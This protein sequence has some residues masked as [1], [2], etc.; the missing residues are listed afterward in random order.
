MTD[1]HPMPFAA[2][3]FERRADE[4]W[5][6]EVPLSRVAEA[7]DT[8]CYVYSR[9]KIETNFR[10]YENAL[11]GTPHL[12]C[13]AMKANSTLGILQILARL[14]AGVDTV[15]GGEIARALRAGFP[16]EKI[17]FS[18]V[19]KTHREIEFALSQKI[20]CFNIESEPELELLNEIASAKGV[21]AP[22]SIR[23]NPDVDAK[24]HPY[25]ST[26]LKNNK[27]GIPIERVEALYLRAA[28]MPGLEVR[29]IDAHIGSQITEVAPFLDSAAK[30]IDVMIRLRA[31]GIRLHHLDIGGG[32]GIRYRPEDTPPEP[33]ELLTPIRTMLNE[34]GL[35]ATEI[36]VEPGRSI[37][38]DA[39]VMLTPVQYVKHGEA[40]D[41][42]IVEGSMSNLIRPA[43]YSAWMAI[44]PV[45]LRRNRKPLIM[46]VV[47][48]VCESSDFLG[49]ARELAVDP[50]DWLA[51]TDAGAYGASMAS[52]YN[53]RPLP[54]E[55]L[56]DGKSIHLLRRPDT[57]EEMVAG[58]LPLIEQGR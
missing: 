27:F 15:S 20:G 58:E 55:Y 40:R 53:S 52:R 12:I 46:D 30:L 25:I 6:E 26:G 3:A 9:A 57:F 35:T 47:G 14:G 34:N 19:G 31:K 28:N 4:L 22:I 50:G 13:Y 24:T 43:L 45:L 11:A 56:I 16:A 37:I 5:C 1:N 10:A 44:E 21:R 18:G 23:C 54:P 51:V 41:F 48:P 36:I 29:G 17:V 39:G 2:P 38:G 7:A 8:T 32:L 33:R 42:C 49:R